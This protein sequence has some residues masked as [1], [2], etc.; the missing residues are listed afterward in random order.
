[1]RS[2]SHIW[3]P[4]EAAKWSQDEQFDLDELGAANPS[5]LRSIPDDV[6]HITTDCDRKVLT[7]RWPK[8]L[9]WLFDDDLTNKT[10]EHIEEYDMSRCQNYSDFQQK[11]KN[12]K[13]RCTLA[14][15]KYRKTLQKPWLS[16]TPK[17]T[18]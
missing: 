6:I 8:A 9:Q 12:E 13:A 16:P 7:F 15:A 10:A 5:I 14:V 18:I 17:T 1:M 4:R 2:I 3:K 11:T